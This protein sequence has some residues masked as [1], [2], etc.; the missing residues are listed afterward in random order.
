MHLTPV[1]DMFRDVAMIRGGVFLLK[2]GDAVGFVEICR[3]Q[4]VEVAGVEGFKSSERRSS[5]F[6]N[7]APT[8]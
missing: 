7:T 3:K 4:G 5:R 1:E 2:P 8:W 6:R